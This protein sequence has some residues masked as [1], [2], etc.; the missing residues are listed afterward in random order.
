MAEYTLGN[1]LGP[2]GPKGDKGDTGPQGSTGAKGATGPQGPKGDTGPQGPKG[3]QGPAGPQGT[4]GSAD[5]VTL[6]GLGGVPA[7]R[8]INGKALSGDIVLKAA[9]V[10]CNSGE[11]MESVLGDIS[12]ILDAINGEVI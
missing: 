9:D 2:Q 11:S 7:T 4:P 3:D 5:N 6:A 1:V 8:K 12:G 10:L